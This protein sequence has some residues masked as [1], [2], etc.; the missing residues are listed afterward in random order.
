MVLI[1]A[2]Q[3]AYHRASYIQFRIREP[4]ALWVM[5]FEYIFVAIL[6]FYFVIAFTKQKSLFSLSE[7]TPRAKESKLLILAKLVI[8]LIVKAVVDAAILYLGNISVEYRFI[9]SDVFSVSYWL[10]AFFVMLRKDSAILKSKSAIL[11]VVAVPAVMLIISTF[12]D[13]NL[14][15]KMTALAEKYTEDSP[16]LIRE[17]KNIEYINCLRSINLETGLIFFLS[18]FHFIKT[19]YVDDTEEDGVHKSFKTAGTITK[20]LFRCLLT[21]NIVALV[22]VGKIFVDYDGMCLDGTVATYGAYGNP[23]SEKYDI[24]C[25]NKTYQWAF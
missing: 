3:Y 9:L 25:D 21:I 2:V 14:I 13:V 6:L 19:K 5:V 18:I 1:L 16:Y 4:Y 12:F 22:A 23:S 24:T 11:T 17:C 7:Y 8:L 10:I 20:T 15:G